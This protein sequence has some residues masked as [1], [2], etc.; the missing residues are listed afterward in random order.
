VSFK[1]LI[2]I[3]CKNRPASLKSQWDNKIG[4]FTYYPI[5]LKKGLTESVKTK[6]V[7]SKFEVCVLFKSY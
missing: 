5:K 7:F 6:C 4:K 2:V 3:V 1:I